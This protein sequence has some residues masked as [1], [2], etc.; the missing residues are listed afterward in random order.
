MWQPSA[1]TEMA[2]PCLCM[3][4]IFIGGKYNLITLRHS[5]PS[6]INTTTNQ[7]TPNKTNTINIQHH[8][9]IIF[10]STWED[11]LM[12]WSLVTTPMPWRIVFH[13]TKSALCMEGFEWVIF[14][15]LAFFSN[16]FQA[17]RRKGKGKNR[18]S[19]H[20]KGTRHHLMWRSHH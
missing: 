5:S 1:V 20:Q 3:V 11:R 13:W 8:E 10:R 16:I 18:G 2:E 7:H 4:R 15:L 9:W 14:D 19:R 6:W 12:S 17:W